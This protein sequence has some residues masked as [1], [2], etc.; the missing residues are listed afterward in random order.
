MVSRIFVKPPE[1]GPASKFIHYII[2]TDHPVEQS[3]LISLTH[4]SRRTV[5]SAIEDL[6]EQGLIIEKQ[7]GRYKKKS[8]S[9]SSIRLAISYNSMKNT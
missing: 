1:G 8:V 3:D 7:S 5:Q 9:A 6:K 4:L 2:K